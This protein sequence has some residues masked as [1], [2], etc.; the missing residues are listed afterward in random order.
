M[1]DHRIR[2]PSVKVESTSILPARRGLVPVRDAIP[3][4]GAIGLETPDTY[5]PVA[6]PRH[7]PAVVR[8]R[9]SLDQ[10]PRA[11]TAYDPV[12]AMIGKV[13]RVPCIVI[14]PAIQYPDIPG[15]PPVASLY[16]DSRE[17][18]PMR[19]DLPGFDIV[20]R[21]DEQPR[22]LKPG[23]IGI[24]HSGS[25]AGDQCQALPDIPGLPTRSHQP[26]SP[27]P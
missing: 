10:Q 8:C 4:H 21:I 25:P 7:I 20:T 18:I 27:D 12:P 5:R 15:A 1:F 19:K 11:M 22:F 6:L 17:S 2:N 23:Y 26:Q 3:D 24:L 9:T 13:R 16:R 14:R